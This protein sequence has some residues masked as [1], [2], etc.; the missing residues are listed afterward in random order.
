MSYFLK[1][2]MASVFFWLNQLQLISA[3]QVMLENI[4]GFPE[5]IILESHNTDICL[6]N[7]HQ[8]YQKI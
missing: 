4:F 1:L 6:K 8:K 3:Y 5:Q 2:Y 7:I